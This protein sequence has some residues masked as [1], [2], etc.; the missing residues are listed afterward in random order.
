MYKQSLAPSLHIKY[1]V[2]SN[3]LLDL[4]ERLKSPRNYSKTD[5]AN[6]QSEYYTCTLFE[7]VPWNYTKYTCIY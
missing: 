4:F 6:D 2:A 7:P 3:L 1:L 5:E